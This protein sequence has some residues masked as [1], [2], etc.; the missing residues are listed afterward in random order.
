MRTAIFRHYKDGKINKF[1]IMERKFQW[2]AF[3]YIPLLFG[4]G[5]LMMEGIFTIATGSVENHPTVALLIGAFCASML[6][7]AYRWGH[8][9]FHKE[10][11]EW[12]A[13]DDLEVR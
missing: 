10:E 7:N 8:G 3:L 2:G 13:V 12:F 1:G 4:C 6:Y 9:E 5:W 11:T